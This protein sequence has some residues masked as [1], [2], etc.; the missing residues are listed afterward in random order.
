MLVALADH[1]DEQV[2]G[3]GGDHDVVDLVERRELV[4]DRLEG[5]ADPDRRSSPAGRSRAR[6][7]SVTATT[8]ITPRVDQP[9]HALADGGLGQPDHLADRGVRA[10]AVLLQLLDDGLGHVVERRTPTRPELDDLLTAG[11]VPAF[12][13]SVKGHRACPGRGIS[14]RLMLRADGFPCRSRRCMTRSECTRPGS[15]T[16]R[17]R[18]PGWQPLDPGTIGDS[19]ADR[20]AA[21]VAQERPAGVALAAGAAAAAGCR[22][23]RERGRPAAVLRHRRG[24]AG[25]A[26]S[27]VRHRPVGETEKKLVFSN[28]PLY[29][30]EKGKR[31]PTLEAFEAADRHRRHLHRRRQRQQP[32][33][34][35]RSATSSAA[36]EPI[37]RDIIVLTDWMA[38]RMIGLGWIQQL[39][40]ANMP[41]VDA[42][43]IDAAAQAA[44]GTRTVDFPCRG[45]AA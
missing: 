35:P 32:S 42:N 12:G 19:A 3:A 28:W 15:T 24:H 26:E 30:D 44:R 45:R 14:L 31:L 6:V 25:P 41:N 38:A 40:E 43:L 17:R 18:E 10:S 36:C 37:E 29:I 11:S 8:C 5:A 2:E 7:G 33:S 9:L 1:L 39:D 34:S 13:A 20:L 22:P 16:P 4:G 27:C 23:G 21:Q